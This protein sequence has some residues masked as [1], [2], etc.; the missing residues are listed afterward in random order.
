MQNAPVNPASR[1]SLVSKVQY[2]NDV[3]D[4]CLLQCSA[5]RVLVQNALRMGKEQS[6]AGMGLAY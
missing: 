5:D 2:K 3:C 1:V 6:V 4:F